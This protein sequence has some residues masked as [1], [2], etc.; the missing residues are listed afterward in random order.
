MAGVWLVSVGAVQMRHLSARMLQ[1]FVR[2]GTTEAVSIIAKGES[3][4]GECS[5][6]SAQGDVCRHQVAVAHAAWLQLPSLE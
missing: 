5:C 2:D 1:A 3:L 6:G 4:I